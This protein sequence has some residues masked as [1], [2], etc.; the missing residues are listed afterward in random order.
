[1]ER[2]REVQ[3]ALPVVLRP[4][5]EELQAVEQYLEQEIRSQVQQLAEL[6]GHLLRSGGKRLRPALVILSAKAAGTYDLKRLITVATCMELIHMAT[7][8]H[9][10]VIDE[11]WTRRGRPT[12]NATF[13]NLAAVLAGDC[14]LSKAMRLLALDGELRI[15]RVVA[16]VTTQMSEG[17]VM[18]VFLRGHLPLSQEDYF[19]V[20]RKK[21]ALF[22]SG[23]SAAGALLA[24]KTE[25]EAQPFATYGYHLGMAFQ[26]VD[27]LLDY[28]GDPKVTGKPVGTDFR[29]GCA[30]LP[31]LHLYEHADDPL[32]AQLQATFGT[33][34]SEREFDRF[35][36]AMQEANSFEYTRQV[37]TQHAQKAIEALS[38]IP[39][40]DAK[41]GLEAVAY[42]V[43]TRST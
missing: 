17:E 37:A 6:G 28:L 12:A 41:K 25:E 4:I 20:I 14:L 7:L 13:G 34:V 36:Q 29:D 27:D 16:E 2:L 3:Q 21:T 38:P 35:M 8:L 11:T 18:Q 43:V 24:G 42:F 1:M 30:T 5:R 26:I 19:E 15:I 40:S 23:C 39:D 10:D 33:P 9:D 31:L 22:L 32:R